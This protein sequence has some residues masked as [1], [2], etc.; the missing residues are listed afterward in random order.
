M[1]ARHRPRTLSGFPS[2]S[3]NLNDHLMRRALLLFP[4]TDEKTTTP[5][6][7]MLVQGPSAEE[8][9]LR[10]ETSMVYTIRLH[11]SPLPRQL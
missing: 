9:R 4:F 7:Y 10:G 6:V 8:V 11:D 1:C 5:E 2:E 3:D